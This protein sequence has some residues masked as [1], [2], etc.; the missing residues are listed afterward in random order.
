MFVLTKTNRGIKKY[1]NQ[2]Y[3]ADNNNYLQTGAPVAF[4]KDFKEGWLE[5]Y[6]QLLNKMLENIL[7]VPSLIILF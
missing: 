7:I 6:W 5:Y 4:Y 2:N 3:K 1:V